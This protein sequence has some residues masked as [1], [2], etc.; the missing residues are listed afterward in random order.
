M[1]VQ[2]FACC[3]RLNDL[4]ESLLVGLKQEKLSPKAIGR[5][6]I[7][8]VIVIGE[9]VEQEEIELYNL[10]LEYIRPELL[11]QWRLHEY[12]ELLDK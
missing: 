2:H 4:K 9:N 3:H 1:N 6:S 7:L 10:W 5:R 8:Q 12:L 11:G